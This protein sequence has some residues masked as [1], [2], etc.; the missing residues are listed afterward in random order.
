MFRFQLT[1]YVEDDTSIAAI[2]LK[3]SE[4]R[5]ITKVQVENVLA[6]QHHVCII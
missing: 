5:Q 6:Q 2:T 3:D 1:L 4:V